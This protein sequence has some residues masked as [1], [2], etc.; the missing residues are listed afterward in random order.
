MSAT[1]T[2]SHVNLPF[3]LPDACQSQSRSQ[4]RTPQPTPVIDTDGTRTVCPLSS[5]DRTQACSRHWASS[6]SREETALSRCV[7]SASPVTYLPSAPSSLTKSR[8]ES[9]LNLR[10]GGS[11]CP[12]PP[13]LDLSAFAHR[14]ADDPSEPTSSATSAT[15]P[16]SSHPLGTYPGESSSGATATCAA[17]CSTPGST[18]ISS[19]ASQSTRNVYH[20]QPKLQLKLPSRR[21]A[22][23][24][25]PS[26]SPLHRQPYPRPLSSHAPR[27]A[28]M[29]RATDSTNA[30][31]EDA[32][33]GGLF[34]MPPP[35]A[36]PLGRPAQSRENENGKPPPIPPR[37]TST[38][39]TRAP[40]VQSPVGGFGI[41][42][43][44]SE[45]ANIWRGGSLGRASVGGSDRD[46]RRHSLAA[47]PLTVSTAIQQ[48]RISPTPIPHPP[49]SLPAPQGP[50]A[51]GQ[52]DTSVSSA[53]PSSFAQYARMIAEAARNVPHYQ[54]AGSDKP[55]KEL[56]VAP[57]IHIPSGAVAS[58]PSPTRLDST[59]FPVLTS[60][61]H[62]FGIAPQPLIAQP[63]SAHFPTEF[64]AVQV[65]SNQG[66]DHPVAS[67]TLTDRERM[68]G[69]DAAELS[70]PTCDF[71]T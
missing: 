70:N 51:S 16:L 23:H 50:N 48:D 15:T 24:S 47:L 5:R 25:D 39:R 43:R 9:N 31:E 40:T 32:L 44:V 4:S 42:R 49:P 7:A 11:R 56:Y 2:Q 34:A 22:V 45:S 57:D 46:G 62:A 52:G 1:R 28:V 66:L 63:Q 65:P 35:P 53:P 29:A 6:A 27:R 12:P 68:L 30:N 69:Y 54:A 19:W 13:W 60:A 21:L 14:P 38:E 71:S 59:N 58:Q 36:E 3:A 33:V 41:Q 67:H 18:P 26:S 61:W 37:P 10:H 64:G 20:P 17:D 8:A 55:S